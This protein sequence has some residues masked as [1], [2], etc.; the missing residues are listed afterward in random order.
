MTSFPLPSP[1]TWLRVLLLVALFNAIVGAPAHEALHIRQQAAETAHGIEEAAWAQAE[2]PS[3][4]TDSHARCAWCL[5]HAFE[6][7]TPPA[8]AGWHGPT[9]AASPGMPAFALSF[10]PD[11]RRWRFASRD[12]PTAVC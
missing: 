9:R 10:V 6:A 7:V 11:A 3:S 12:P 8:P 4:D 2:E 1:R 5:T